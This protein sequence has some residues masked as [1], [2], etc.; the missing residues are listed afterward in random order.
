GC[1]SKKTRLKGEKNPLFRPVVRRE[2]LRGRRP[3]CQRYKLPD[4]QRGG[5]CPLK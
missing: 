1:F 4:V 3:C 5:D 2:G